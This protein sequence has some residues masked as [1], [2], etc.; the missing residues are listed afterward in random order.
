MNN[1]EYHKYVGK[2]L[3]PI[4]LILLMITYIFIIFSILFVALF[5]KYY[6]NKILLILNRLCIYISG[7]NLI[8]EGK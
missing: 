4:R 6:T 5:S 2:L 8:L 1:Y 7:I 3:F